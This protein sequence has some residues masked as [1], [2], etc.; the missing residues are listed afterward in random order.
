[1]CVVE[2]QRF[3]SFVKYWKYK[4]LN[5][6]TKIKNIDNFV[7]VHRPNI[8]CQYARVRQI[9]RFYVRPF[10]SNS[11]TVNFQKID[12]EIEDQRLRLYAAKELQKQWNSEDFALNLKIIDIDDLA[13]NV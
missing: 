5:L 9:W 10:W 8:P 3:L 7:E 4:R 6:K 11:K 1:M 13:E 2:V 12:L